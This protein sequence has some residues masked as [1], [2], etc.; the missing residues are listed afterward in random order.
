[1]G[2]VWNIS[3]ANI[4]SRA[5]APITL[6]RAIDGLDIRNVHIQENGHTAIVCQRDAVFKNARV[7]GIFA[8][9]CARVGSVLDFGTVEGEL[10]VSDVF[11]DKAEH[12][13]RNSGKAKVVFENVHVR[14]LTG[15]PVV[16]ADDGPH[17]FDD[18][19]E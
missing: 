18:T 12:L 14:E 5:A 17:W 3:I 8:P 4:W 2:D 1:M 16:D 7:S 6:F 11:V 10:H 19:E 13:M 9:A 15:D